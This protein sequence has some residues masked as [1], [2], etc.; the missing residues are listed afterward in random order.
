M[1][2]L[3]HGHNGI[4]CPEE[5]PIVKRRHAIRPVPSRRNNPVHDGDP[6]KEPSIAWVLLVEELVSG[7]LQLKQPNR[8]FL[9][10]HLRGIS[11]VCKNLRKDG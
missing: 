2:S 3:E 5:L 8:L 9:R 10:V 11:V 7:D 1:P 4:G 6:G